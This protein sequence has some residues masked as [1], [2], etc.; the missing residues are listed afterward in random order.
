MMRRFVRQMLR[1]VLEAM[2]AWLCELLLGRLVL[3]L[4]TLCSWY[5]GTHTDY[6][7]AT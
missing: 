1:L 3:L 2:V 5:F 6:I 4:V 7:S